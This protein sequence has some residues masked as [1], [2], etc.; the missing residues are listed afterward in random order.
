[1]PLG[2]LRSAGRQGSSQ[3]SWAVLQAAG[4]QL[5]NCPA[6]EA[7]DERP[8]AAAGHGAN[9]RMREGAGAGGGR[10][11]LARAGRRSREAGRILGS[12]DEAAGAVG[13][14]GGGGARGGSSRAGARVLDCSGLT[15]VLRD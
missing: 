8:L 10:R 12:R 15:S 1:M 9:V 13:V 2:P 6:A 14:S 7:S 5:G 4:L 3:L 11:G